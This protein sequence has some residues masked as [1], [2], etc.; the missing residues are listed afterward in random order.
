V[1]AWPTSLRSRLTLSYTVLLA[2]PLVVFAIV[3]Y[4][5]FQGALL[6]R[7]DRFIGDALDAFS[8]E[9]S[10]ERRATASAEEAMRTTVNEVRFRDLQVAILDSA[11]R[12]VATT[13]IPDDGPNIDRRPPPDAGAR[14]F[15]ELRAHDVAEP[16]AIDVATPEGTYRVISRPLTLR[17]RMFDVTGS[18]SLSDV[19][20]VLSRIRLMFV[21]AIPLLLLTAA[22]SGYFLAKRNLAPMSLMAARAAEIGATNLHERLPVAGGD[23]LVRLA[24]VVNDLLDRLEGSFEQQRQFMADAS[25]ELRTP[26]AILRTEADVTLARD[27]R[28]ETDYRA[29]IAVMQDAARRLTR[30]VDDLFLLAR[31]DSGH[32][33][34]RREAIDLEDLVHDTARGVRHVADARGVR[35]ALGDVIEAPIQGDAD[36][37]GRLLLNLLDNAIKHSPRGG[38]VD[39]QMQQR[40]GRYEVS[41]ADAGAGI[42]GE[43]QGRVFERFFRVDS[44]RSRAENSATSGAGLGL[45]I[46]RRIADMHGGRLE[47]VESRPGRTEFRL[48]LPA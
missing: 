43:A 47:L 29:S 28:D 18:Y 12:V 33:V 41:V 10:A 36:L 34:A 7:T 35:I 25:H 44:V 42:P 37:L 20:D 11:R 22:T 45:A 23:E 3:C 38:S 48:V 17:G 13:G 39:V 14:I 26:T 8:R 2:L 32:L 24:R 31:A 1:R 46:A 27:H 30:I 21:A 9:L 16:L 4:L 19:Q 5:V 6:R 40:D 15:A